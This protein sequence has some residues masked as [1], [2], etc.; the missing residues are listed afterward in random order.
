MEVAKLT[1]GLSEQITFVKPFRSH[2]ITMSTHKT[3]ECTVNWKKKYKRKRGISMFTS[4]GWSTKRATTAKLSWNILESQLEEG[5]CSNKPPKYLILIIMSITSWDKFSSGKKIIETCHLRLL[6]STRMAIQILYS[7]QIIS[8]FSYVW[9]I[10]NL[11]SESN[12]S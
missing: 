9:S 3:A 2:L 8:H 5:Y 7:Y 6:Q 12:Y 4:S 10:P 11:H 1:G